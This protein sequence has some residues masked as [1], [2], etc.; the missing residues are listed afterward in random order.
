MI[1]VRVSM[2]KDHS[3]SIRVRNTP[4]RPGPAA[5]VVW[6][7]LIPAELVILKLLIIISFFLCYSGQLNDLS[8][9]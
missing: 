2:P 8:I 3:W 5:G 9:Y 7:L 6:S 4:N 1:Q